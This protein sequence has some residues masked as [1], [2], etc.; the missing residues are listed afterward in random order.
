MTQAELEASRRLLSTAGPNIGRPLSTGAE[1]SRR[2][3][4]SNIDR[5]SFALGDADDYSRVFTPLNSSN[6]PL[7][8]NLM[9]DL[10]GA[11]T[12]RLSHPRNAATTAAGQHQMLG[13][14]NRPRSVIEGDTSFLFSSAGSSWLNPPTH[15]SAGSGSTMGR[16]SSPAER[17]KSADISLWTLPSFDI[18]KD[19]PQ[20]LDKSKRASMQAFL[21]PS[22]SGMNFSDLS[23]RK[24]DA[25]LDF[26]SWDKRR[27]AGRNNIP[28]TLLELDEQF[29]SAGQQDTT[30][31]STAVDSANLVLSPFDK[32][33]RANSPV[34]A[35]SA[36]APFSRRQQMPPPGM[37]RHYGQ[38][39]NPSDA[40]NHDE[41]DYLSDH[42]EASNVSVDGGNHNRGGKRHF[43]QSYNHGRIVRD[44]KASDTVDME[45]LEGRAGNKRQRSSKT[46]PKSHAGTAN[47]LSDVPAWFRTLRL[48]KY[49]SIFEPMKWQDIIK[50][51]DED[52]QAKGVAALGARRKMLKVFENIRAHC[53]AN[54]GSFRYSCYTFRVLTNT[55][56]L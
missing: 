5:H 6:N 45:L 33:R 40:M 23:F 3:G 27:R 9:D 46:L 10:S 14:G 39:L 48:H 41:H 49:N 17:P 53:E 18:S 12:A 42:S 1:S 22:S 32:H 50:L 38:Y 54:V 28:G 43:R 11:R 2:A 4:T 8:F 30:S 20:L 51:T 21:A 29:S 15:Q 25:D 52:L 24:L 13:L 19:D 16:I 26:A 31:S 36:S 44:K 34:P 47:F 7:N 56:V 35:A 55:I 37:E